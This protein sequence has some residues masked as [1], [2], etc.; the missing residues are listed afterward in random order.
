MHAPHQ[1]GRPGRT[2][3]YRVVTGLDDGASGMPVPEGRYIARS[4][5]GGRTVLISVPT[6]GADPLRFMAEADSSRYL[7]G[8]WSSPA[9]ELAGPDEAPWHARPYLPALPLP[10]ALLVH[11]GPLPERTVRAIGAA[12]V[13]TLSI[14]HGQGLAHAGVS[15][16][17][18]L[19]A[20]DGPRLGCFGAVRVAA[21]DGVPRSGLPGLESGSLPPEQAAGG[22]PDPMG[23]IYALGA[24]LAYA[25][26]GHTVPESHQFPAALRAVLRR[27]VSRDPAARP[28]PA[29]LLDVFSAVGAPVTGPASSP[30]P[31]PHPATEVDQ[32]P[33][34]RAE[35][36]LGPGWLPGRVIAAIAHQSAR[37]LAAEP[38]ARQPVTTHRQD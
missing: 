15:P 3:P 4:A 8:P 30:A 23:D 21:P 38:S 31:A 16:A 33:A 37:V 6:E 25:A 2:G 19:L 5:D 36:V 22:R 27:C 20:A 11:G 12:L 13:E 34:S 26:T 17:A 32:R 14:G 7:L 24:T 1:G 28:R 35:A 29:E 18:V 9:T 10:T